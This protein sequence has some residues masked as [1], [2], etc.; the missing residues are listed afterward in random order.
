VLIGVKNFK[1][2]TMFTTA[3]KKYQEVSPAILNKRTSF[4]NPGIQCKLIVSQPD[5]VYEREADAMADKVM[6]MAD[7]T[8]FFF[9]PADASV[10]RKC[11]HCEEEPKELHRKEKSNDDVRAGFELDNYVG[12]LSGNGQYLSHEAR[13]FFEPRFGQDF[14]S[15]RVH[16]DS[17]AARSA[18]SINALA[19]T[20]DDNIVFNHGQYAP[21]TDNGKKLLGHELTHVLQQQSAVY[22]NK[23]QRRPAPYIK[24]VTVHLAPPQTADLEWEGTPPAE[25]TG[26]DHFT[27][28]TGKGYSN[29][30]DPAGTCTRSCCSNADT[31]CAPPY[32]QPGR[33]GACCTYHGDNFWTGTS[34]DEHNGWKWWTPVQPYYGSRGIAL[35]Q[36]STVTGQPIGHGCVRM[37]E[38]NAK[39][40]HDFS[41]GQRTNV[42][43]EGRAA[44]V[45]CDAGERCSAGSPGSPATGLTES[46]PDDALFAAGNNETQPAVEGL[47]GLLS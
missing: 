20:S 13:S 6:G 32:N 30:G 8:N 21:G 26:S 17:D 15:V 36:H 45:E 4:F 37:D 41:N 43:I 7:A 42:T 12:S 31:Q 44:P 47:E 9:K 35:H 10:Q 16:N 25:A 19:Y 14:S 11:Q 28:S 39:R 3:S 5:D 22:S 2:C 34:L 27:V 24:K 38:A 40:I 1:F 29:P 33:V 18:Q 23:I 46:S